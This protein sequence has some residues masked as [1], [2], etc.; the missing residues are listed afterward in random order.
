[1]KSLGTAVRAI[2]VR[3]GPTARPWAGAADELDDLSLV[4]PADVERALAAEP[5]RA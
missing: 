3:S 4:T 5:A 2:I 1:V